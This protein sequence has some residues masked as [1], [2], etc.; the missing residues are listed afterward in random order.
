M[1]NFLNFLKLK[2]TGNGYEKQ[3]K[4]SVK[5]RFF[6]A[7]QK[8]KKFNN[9]KNTMVVRPPRHAAIARVSALRGYKCVC[10]CGA[11]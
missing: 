9:F 8:K 2:T 10:V 1:Q 3:K 5:T 4:R 11:W 7:A 6:Y